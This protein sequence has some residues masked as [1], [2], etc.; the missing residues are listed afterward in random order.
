MELHVLVCVWLSVY[1]QPEPLSRTEFQALIA[2]AYEGL[3]DIQ[4]EWEGTS[5]WTAKAPPPKGGNW[6]LWGKVIYRRGGPLIVERKDIYPDGRVERSLTRAATEKLEQLG[7]PGRGTPYL[8]AETVKGRYPYKADFYALKFFRLPFFDLAEEWQWK[9]WRFLR[10]EEERVAVV[11]FPAEYHRY[12]IDFS[13][14]AALK[15]YEAFNAKGTTM[16]TLLTES[17]A[18][19]RDA[20]GRWWWFPA[21]ITKI[22]FATWTDDDGPIA[23]W[24]ARHGVRRNEAFRKTTMRVLLDTVRINTGVDLPELKKLAPKGTMLYQEGKLAGVKGGLGQRPQEAAEAERQ[25]KGML[26][27]A[28]RQRGAAQAISAARLPWW[29]RNWPSLLALALAI[30]LLLAAWRISRASS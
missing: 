6:R 26:A 2:Q 27:E 7:V 14:S 16:T 12:W 17:F 20:G 28:E 25:L 11:E 9:G 24:Y 30:A 19:V 15:R 21:E 29:R 3:K 10:W 22:G 13:H 5:L 8:T 1:G 23:K 4:F 18:Q